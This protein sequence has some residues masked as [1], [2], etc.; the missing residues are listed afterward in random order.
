MLAPSGVVRNRNRAAEERKV[1]WKQGGCGVEATP[2]QAGADLK[3]SDQ[4]MG[5]GQKYQECIREEVALHML[6]ISQWTEG[7]MVLWK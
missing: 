5:L 2:Q 6:P 4:Q 3:M 1:D 7:E